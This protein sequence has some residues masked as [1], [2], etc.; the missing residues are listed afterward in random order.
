MQTVLAWPP[1]MEARSNINLP[2]RQAFNP[3]QQ[4]VV[5]RQW[6]AGNERAAHASALAV[7]QSYE[8]PGDPRDGQ[9]DYG[10]RHAH[11]MHIEPLNETRQ[12]RLQRVKARLPPVQTPPGTGHRTLSWPAAN[13]YEPG[14]WPPTE[15]GGAA[16]GG[17]SW[18]L[19]DGFQS[20]G[21]F[22]QQA[23]RDPMTRAHRSSLAASGTGFRRSS[24]PRRSRSP[25]RSSGGGSR[26]LSPRR[27]RMSS[28]TGLC[29][30]SSLIDPRREERVMRLY[31]EAHRRRRDDPQGLNVPVTQ[32]TGLEYYD[33]SA[34]IN[35]AT[36]K[37]RGNTL[38]LLQL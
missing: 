33:N 25:A 29:R 31:N 19:N 23:A 4:S 9:G 17:G 10:L 16:N 22:A 15:G 26:S 32:N 6:N 18:H 7:R 14:G 13:A 34:S 11:Q 12:G 21:A 1:S 38:K 37:R 35:M 28:P 5:W 30:N 2:G 36:G 24:S 20:T 8:P 3:V 27:G